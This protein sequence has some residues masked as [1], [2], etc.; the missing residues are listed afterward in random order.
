MGIIDR[1]KIALKLNAFI[2]TEIKEAQTMESGTPGYKT[3]EFWLNLM[4]QAGVVWGSIQ[5]LIP[6]KYA[7]IIA[8]VGTAFYTVARTVAKAVADIQATKAKTSTVIT[9]E[10]VT[11]V[12]T[13]AEIPNEKIT[14]AV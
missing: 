8:V 9:T 5:G 14:K 3:T 13:P 2:K 7:A 6:P 10:P 4:A 11:T 12:T 1:I